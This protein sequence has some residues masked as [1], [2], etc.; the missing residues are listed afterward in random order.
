MLCSLC[1]DYQGSERWYKQL[2]HFAELRKRSDA[3]AKEARSRLAWLDI[4]L[5]QRKMNGMLDSFSRAFRL[6][7]TKEVALPPFSVTEHLA[8]LDEWRQGFSVNG[9]KKTIYFIKR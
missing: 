1:T 6:M 7:C 2:Q 3:S 4:S 9:V 5:P 8:Q